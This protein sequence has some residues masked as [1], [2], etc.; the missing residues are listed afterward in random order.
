M[1]GSYGFRQ[2][3]EWGCPLVLCRFSAALELERLLSADIRA[4]THP[5]HAEAWTTNNPCAVGAGTPVLKK[6]PKPKTQKPAATGFVRI[7]ILLSSNGPM[8]VE[9]TRGDDF[10]RPAGAGRRVEI[11]DCIIRQLGRLFCVRSVSVGAEINAAI[12]QDVTAW[13]QRVGEDENGHMIIGGIGLPCEGEF[14]RG[15]GDW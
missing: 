1:L 8:L 12:E 3:L 5:G 15:P 6:I 14:F 4:G 10:A 11:D 2:V 13:I 9:E 7:S